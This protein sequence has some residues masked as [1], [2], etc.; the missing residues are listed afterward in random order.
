MKKLFTLVALLTCFMGAQAKTVVDAEINF[1][2]QTAVNWAW[3][4]LV[5]GA[6]LDI[7]DGCLHYSSP[8]LPEG[9]NPWDSQFV[10]NGLAG[11]NVEV[12][13]DYTFEMEIKGSAAGNW[14]LMENLNFQFQLNGRFSK[15]CIQL[16]LL[17]IQTPNCSVVTMQVSGGLSTS[18]LP[19][20]RLMMKRLSSGRTSSRMAML[21]PRGMIPR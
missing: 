4:G 1:A 7:Q 5:E 19:M 21:L 11:I 20:R 8:G 12:G 16:Y 2:E 15:R 10:L 17:K 14:Q 9:A 3:G 18:R 13:V 6:V